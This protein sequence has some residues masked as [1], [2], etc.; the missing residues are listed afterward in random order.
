[1]ELHSKRLDQEPWEPGGH[2]KG[3]AEDGEPAPAYLI[4]AT[5]L[6]S[7]VLRK[8]KA[9][10]YAATLRTT[11]K[12]CTSLSRASRHHEVVAYRERFS[13]SDLAA[14]SM[15]ADPERRGI[16]IASLPSSSQHSALFTPPT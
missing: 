13:M 15:A 3:E 12:G 5:E 10:T 2:G 1:M 6:I 16:A 4:Q 7:Q 9:G 14:V 8:E 11:K